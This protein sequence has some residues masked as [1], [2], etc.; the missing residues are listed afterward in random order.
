MA[1]SQYFLFMILMVCSTIHCNRERN[2]RNG[3]NGRNRMNERNEMNRG[4]NGRGREG[5][6]EESRGNWMVIYCQ[7]NPSAALVTAW[8]NCFNQRSAG[9]C[10]T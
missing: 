1:R 9:V 5:R 10:L 7:A 8:G 6:M 2:E 3:M 4:Q